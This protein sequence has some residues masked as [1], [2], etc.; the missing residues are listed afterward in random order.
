MKFTL[1]YKSLYMILVVQKINFTSGTKDQKEAHELQLDI[2][3]TNWNRNKRTTGEPHALSDMP[4][5]L[6]WNPPPSML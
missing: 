4:Y 5:Q 1:E 2:S 6:Q 3:Q